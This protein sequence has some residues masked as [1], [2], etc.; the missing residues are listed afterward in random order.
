MSD[1]EKLFTAVFG[2]I[3]TLAIISVIV[4]Q[5]SQAPQAITAVAGGISRVVAA[6][7]SPASTA[8]NGNNGSNTFSTPGDVASF[9]TQGE[10][11]L[12]SFSSQL[13]SLGINV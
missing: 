4:G 11:T 2:G 12:A 7:V 10:S 9:L 3:L 6:A 13:G 8:T 5:K 1:I